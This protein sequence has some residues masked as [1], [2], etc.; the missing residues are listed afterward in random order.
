MFRSTECTEGYGFVCSLASRC[1]YQ[2]AVQVSL[3]EILLMLGFYKVEVD[4]LKIDKS[5]IVK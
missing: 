5:G 3:L 2:Y 1:Q 4:I